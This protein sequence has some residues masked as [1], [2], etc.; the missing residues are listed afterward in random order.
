MCVSLFISRS[1]LASPLFSLLEK[2]THTNSHTIARLQFLQLLHFY[3]YF[4]VCT[5]KILAP[6]FATRLS[7]VRS[8]QVSKPVNKTTARYQEKP[9]NSWRAR[10]PASDLSGKTPSTLS[11]NARWFHPRVRTGS[12]VQASTQ[13][14]RIIPYV[15]VGLSSRARCRWGVMRNNF[16]EI[17]ILGC[18]RKI[19]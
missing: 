7:R 8:K 16:P 9:A 5:C 12:S 15:L 18:S 11:P 2:A 13:A 3:F 14:L 6:F 17:I 4:Y 19:R 1:G 10:T